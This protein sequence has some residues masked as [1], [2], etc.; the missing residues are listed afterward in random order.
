MKRIWIASVVL[1]WG[2][3][4]TVL[5]GLE[6]VTG[7]NVERFMG[8]WYEIERIENMYETGL[9]N[10]SAEYFLSPDGNIR[11]IHRGFH[12]RRNSWS[13]ATGQISFVGSRDVG[14]FKITFGSPV[15]LPYNVLEIDPQY[16]YAMVSGIDRDSL[17]ILSREPQL[18]R[19]ILDSLVAKAKTLGFSTKNLMYVEQKAIQ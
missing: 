10:V 17:W 5:E 8:K 6:P 12:P 15:P 18:D 7:F 13:I 19:S 2:C 4:T 11:V 1:L 3:A 16:R 9:G 14:S